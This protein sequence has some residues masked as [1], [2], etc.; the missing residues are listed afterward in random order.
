MAIVVSVDDRRRLARQ[1]GEILRH[2]D[3]AKVMIAEE[4]LERHRRRQLAGPDQRSRDLEYAA[5][6]FLD[7]VLAPQE[8]R[9]AVERV[10]VDE[11]RA[12]QRLFGLEVVRRRA[13]GA[14]LRLCLA[15]GK[16]FDRRHGVER[17]FRVQGLVANACR[18]ESHATRLIR[19]LR[20][21][22][23]HPCAQ[24]SRTARPERR[25]AAKKITAGRIGLRS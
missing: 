2:G 7:E 23:D 20:L 9:D 25:G 22:R 24:M 1:A 10:I 15:L 19:R 3:A 16:L 17:V 4:R 8:V 12:E 13:I 5:M 21:Q 6:N 14:I 11:D 18:N